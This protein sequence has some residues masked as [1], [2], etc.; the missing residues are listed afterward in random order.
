MWSK[1][2]PGLHVVDPG[3]RVTVGCPLCT[4][5]GLESMFMLII[6]CVMAVYHVGIVLL[7]YVYMFYITGGMGEVFMVTLTRELGV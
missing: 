2:R 6:S 1:I 5:F 3:E 7:M 4:F